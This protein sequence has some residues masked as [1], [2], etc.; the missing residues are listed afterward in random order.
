MARRARHLRGEFAAASLKPAAMRSAICHASYLRGEFAAASLKQCASQPSPA[1]QCP[2]LRGEFAAA[3][4]KPDWA[5]GTPLYFEH[6]RGEFAAASLKP[7]WA[8]GTPL[9]FEH[10]RG[11]FAAASLKQFGIRSKA[12]GEGV[13]PRRIRRGLIEAIRRAVGASADR[14]SPRRIRRGLIEAR[15]KGQNILWILLHLRGEFAAAS[16]KLKRSCSDNYE[17]L[18]SAANSPRPH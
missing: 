18:I 15:S 8:E 6:L 17:K 4:L 7:D 2:N 1:R 16:L 11:E 12:A 10:L 3:S 9:Y 5:A 13:S 14:P